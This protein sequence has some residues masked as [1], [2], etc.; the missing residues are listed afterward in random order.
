MRT[1]PAVSSLEAFR[2]PAFVQPLTPVAGR[3][4]K[5]LN[6]SGPW[7]VG[8]EARATSRR[9]KAKS[10]P[11]LTQ[12]PGKVRRHCFV[13]ARFLIGSD[14]GK[15]TECQTSCGLTWH[16]GK[17]NSILGFIEK[18]EYTA[19]L[20]NIAMPRVD[21]YNENTAAT[22]AVMFYQP[23][24]NSRDNRRSEWIVEKANQVAS[25]QLDLSSIDVNAAHPGLSSEGS[26]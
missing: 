12:L 11:F 13:G 16:I 17:N 23:L 1:P 3:R 26:P 10:L 5:T 18:S 9:P 20:E 4:P 15:K 14:V 7:F 19:S 21:I 6:D 24:G 22:I 8:T 25:W 2:T